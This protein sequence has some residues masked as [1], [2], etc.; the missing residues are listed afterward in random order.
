MFLPHAKEQRVRI[1]T[2]TSKRGRRLKVKLAAVRHLMSTMD[3]HADHLNRSPVGGAVLPDIPDMEL[4][5]EWQDDG[6]PRPL[7]EDSGS[8]EGE[9][10]NPAGGEQRAAP[11]TSLALS[12]TAGARAKK[13]LIAPSLNLM[14]SCGDSHDGFSSSGLSPMPDEMLSLDI[15]LEALETPSDSETGTLP[16][17]EG[18]KENFEP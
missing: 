8:P 14:L 9:A 16:G 13:R 1:A 17:G 18:Q 10:E 5:E 7:P 15:N 12:G 6:F 4:K 2:A 11:P 3:I